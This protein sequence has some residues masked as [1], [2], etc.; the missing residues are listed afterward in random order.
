MWS[1]NNVRTHSLLICDV[2]CDDVFT[3][4]L[5]KFY[6][7]NIAGIVKKVFIAGVVGCKLE[8][9]CFCSPIFCQKLELVIR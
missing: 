8:K 9:I 7:L 3:N 2:T 5:R 4:S 1:G 6:Y